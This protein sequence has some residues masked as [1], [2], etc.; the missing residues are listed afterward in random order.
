ML[1]KGRRLLKVAVIVIILFLSVHLSQKMYAEEE[2]NSIKILVL[3]SYSQ[4]FTW[5][6]EQTEGIKDKLEDYDTNISLFVEYM[7]CK[8]YPTKENLDYLFDY[9]KFKYQNKKIDIII[10]TDDAAL[11]FALENRAKI[12]SDAPIVFCGVNQ[13]GVDTITKGYDRVTGVLEVIDPTETLKIAKNINPSLKTIYIL[14][15]NSD[16]GLSTGNIVANAIKKYD[17]NIE[18]IEWN[19]L[20]YEE[21]IREASEL[22]DKNS[23]I[24]ICTYFSDVNNKIIKMDDIT[25][26]ISEISKVPL[27]YLYDFGLNNGIIGGSLQS[28]RLQGENAA[29][30][31]IS[32][33]EGKDPNNMP[34]FIAD[35][36]R[37][38][39]DYNQILRF[40]I[41]LNALPKNSELINKPFSF[42]ETYKPLVLGVTAAFFVLL[43]FASSLLFYIYK[44]QKMKQK[45]SESHEELTQ[46]YKELSASDEAMK[47]QYDEITKINEKIRLSEEKLTYLAYHDSITG[48]PNKL[49]LYEHA[50][51]IFEAENK[52]AGLLFIDIDN[53]K[54]VND[55]LG[56][57]FGD[58]LIVN[59]SDR[60]TALLKE[61]CSLYRLSGDEFIIILNNIDNK[62]Q[63]EE[64][65][66][67][68]LTN[69]LK[70]F[71]SL[72]SNLHVS[73]SIGIALYPDHSNELEQLLKYADI[74]MYHVKEAGRK[75]YMVYD[76]TMNEAFTERVAIEKHLQNAFDNNEFQVYYQPQL[77]IR[78][79]KISGFEALLRWNSPVLGSVS[80]L[81]FIKVA[82]DTHFI[83]PLGK[84]VL[85][86]AC[87]FLKRLKENGY[88]DLTVS[89]NISILQLLQAD[90]IDFVNETLSIYQIEPELLELEITESILIESFEIVTPRLQILRDNKVKIALDDFGKGYSS[91]SYL[92]Q[93]P[94]TT[95][96]VDKT[97][98][99]Y[100]VGQNEDD[101]VGHIISIGKNMGMCVIAEG[102]EHQN[103]LDYLIRHD[104]DKIQGFLFSRPI[105]E[106]KIYELLD[107]QV[108]PYCQ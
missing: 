44:I 4:D 12:F 100:I 45:L 101:F 1:G 91:L 61:N 36:T 97:F 62:K 20:T 14:Y 10:A 84:L 30:M 43:I 81:K 58:K 48:L 87:D 59:V 56:H 57:A 28:G 75:N 46:L 7:D 71:D 26:E 83:I 52:K 29:A 38:V 21:V 33:I 89:V 25:R 63:A 68:L 92:K 93:L 79:N 16:S 8:N 35:T 51:Y 82:E 15:D 98:I 90:F 53:C 108:P 18:I 19:N 86:N 72:G 32:I 49:S 54:Y 60:L 37:T 2:S 64:Y 42:Y 76:Q 6:D 47:L 23:I 11:Q 88:S 34:V 105:P 106:N 104:C 31:A 17:S 107:S 67:F 69:F 103:Q 27:Y 77:D 3:N 73:L 50:K 39:F 94:I 24:M 85:Q 78:T 41:P 99:D 102:V 5:T 65:A 40:D 9:Y 66:S 96:K 74:A 13:E 55:T 70:D 80:P 95:L 22:N